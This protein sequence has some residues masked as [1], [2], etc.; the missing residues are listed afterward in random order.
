MIFDNIKNI[1]NYL[2]NDKICEA[3]KLAQTLNE[4]SPLGKVVINDNL[5][6]TVMQ[7][8]GNSASGASAETHDKWADIQM[9]LSGKEQI[10]IAK[11]ED[12]TVATP[13]NSERDIALWKGEFTFL[14]LQKGDFVVLFPQ[15]AHA[16]SLNVDSKPIKKAVL[17]VR[18]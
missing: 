15:E 11:V 3:L 1:N 9:V 17:K 2:A 10:G 13:Y 5:Y 14:Q 4:N 6:Y 16:P 12:L 8:D 7:I 18:M